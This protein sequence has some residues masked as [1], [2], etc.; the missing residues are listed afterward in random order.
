MELPEGKKVYFASDFHLG[1]PD[2][3]TSI[4]REK[5][6]CQW[7]DEIRHDAAELFLVGDIFDVW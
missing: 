4:A 6:L 5:R 3:A 1:I 2:K 7:L